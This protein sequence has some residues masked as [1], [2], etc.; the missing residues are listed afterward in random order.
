[1][2][3]TSDEHGLFQFVSVPHGSYVITAE[4]TG[5]GR[6]DRQNVAVDGDTT[7]IVRYETKAQP[8]QPKT[9]ATIVVS[10]SGLHINVTAASIASISP[11][12]YAFEGNPPWR[13]LVEQVPGVG[14]GGALYGGGVTNAVIP[15]SPF[16][17]VV[18]TI[19]GAQPYE[20]STTMDGMPLENTT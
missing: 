3:T 17:P 5:F 14:V 13:D 20:T 1:L 16:Q 4:A 12:E 8:G 19:N 2:S 6:V 9:L 10:S 11:P 7:V 18:L 15:D